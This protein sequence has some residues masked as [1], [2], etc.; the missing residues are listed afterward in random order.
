MYFFYFRVLLPLIGR[1]FSGNRAA[2]RYLPESVMQF[3]DYE[4]FADL[5]KYAGFSDVRYIRLTGGI[6]CIYTGMK[7]SLQ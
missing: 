2:Y 1:L 3:P 7:T 4:K 5:L 6:A